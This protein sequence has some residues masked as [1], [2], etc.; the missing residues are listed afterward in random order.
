MKP[1][2]LCHRL[3]TGL[4]GQKLLK[5][6]DKHFPAGSKLH[7]IFNKSTVKVSYSCM[8]NMGT[9]ITCHNARVCGA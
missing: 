8:P 4:I 9:I 1:N 5:L 3:A 6:I 7:K 2:P